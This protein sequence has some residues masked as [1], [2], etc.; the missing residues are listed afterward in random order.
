MSIINQDDI[1]KVLISYNPWWKSGEVPK[2]T[3]KNMK[4]TVYSEAQEAFLKKDIRRFV[5]LTG[6]RRVG[7]TTILYQQI[8]QLIE[9]GIDVKNILYVSFDNPILKFCK[10]NTLLEL[11][12]INISGEGEKYLF[13]DEI[14]YAEDWDNWLKVIYDQS[15][16]IHVMATGSASP[17][18]KQGVAE[19]G[20]GRWITIT[21]P[22]LSFYE[23]CKL[24]SQSEGERKITV[25]ELNEMPVSE[26]NKLFVNKFSTLINE[27]QEVDEKISKDLKIEDLKNLKEKELG[28]IVNTLSVLQKHFNR[29][30]KIGGFP[31]LVLSSDDIYSER[32][33]RED[34]V[35]KVLKR[36][37]PSLFGIRNVSIL[38]KVFLYLCFESSNIINYT[39]MSQELENTSVATIQDYILYLKNANLIYESKPIKNKILKGNPKVYIADSAIRNAVLMKDDIITDSTEMGYSVETAVYRHVFTY[40]SKYKGTTGYYREPKTEKEIDIVGNSLKANLYIE[41][42]YREKTKTNINRNNPLYELPNENDNIFI[43]TKDPLDYGIIKH[44]NKKIVKIPAFAFIYILGRQE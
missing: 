22:T 10:L 41:V 30:I 31:E 5:L 19:S 11:Y 7:K 29:Y 17:V 4:R 2:E 26:V 42:K 33:L 9:N 32:I 39:A 3:L 6:A 43:I 36:D 23:Y 21:V 8:E 15:T 40:M 24:K 27:L 37:M 25:R 20:A 18:I 16:N 12:D 35:D 38:E 28:D 34:I 13:L 44:E 1:L 14:Q